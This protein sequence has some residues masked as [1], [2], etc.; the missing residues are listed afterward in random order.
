MSNTLE[1]PMTAE[2]QA[3]DDKSQYGDP[4]CNPLERSMTIRI[5]IPTY[6]AITMRALCEGV[7]ESTV[8]R[9]WMRRGALQEGINIDRLH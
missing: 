3:V 6:A 8:V 2:A 7:G 9:R 1:Q 5:S 4:L